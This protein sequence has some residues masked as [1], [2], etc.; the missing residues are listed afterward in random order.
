MNVR[1]GIRILSLV[2]CFA[3]LFGTNA[4]SV[5]AATIKAPAIVT[6]VKAT[7]KGTNSIKVTWKKVASSNGYQIYRK[8][9]KG[10]W[11]KIT[12]IKGSNKISY[13]NKL[14]KANKKYL[15]KV[16][17]YK[18]YKSKGKTKYK[19]AKFSKVVSATTK[20][21]V[22]SYKL[23]DGY[24]TAGIDIPAGTLDVIA[25]GGCG[26]IMA[27]SFSAN[28]RGPEY[29]KNDFDD[30]DDYSRSKESCKLAKG[31]ILEVKGV[32]IKLNYSKTTSSAPGRKYDYNNGVLLKS[33]TYTVGEDITPGRYCVKY[34]SGSGG[35]VSSERY[36]G[37]CILSSNMDGDSKTGD[38]MDFVSNIILVKGETFEI[39]D[40][41]KLM[42]IPEKK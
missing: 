28:L 13:I 5:D 2:L 23:Q 24:Y 18:T 8:N 29:K 4:V 19:Y 12:N 14:L 39:T 40:G 22:S 15:Y 37:E 38:Y 25:T 20:K 3:L 27:D 36:E 16:R 34:V 21:V 6:K 9:G 26:Y 30:F 7:A 42:F 17:A 33:G 31:E 41:L 35:Y 11:K 1:K 32:Q 10:K